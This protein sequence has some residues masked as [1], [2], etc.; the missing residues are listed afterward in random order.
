MNKLFELFP[1]ARVGIARVRLIGAGVPATTNHTGG[2]MKKFSA[3]LLC[4]ALAVCPAFAKKTSPPAGP[5]ACKP[6]I[7]RVVRGFWRQRGYQYR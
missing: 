6:R 1:V 3:F 4:A 7:G 5:L 2:S